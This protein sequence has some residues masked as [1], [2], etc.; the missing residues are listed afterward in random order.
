MFSIAFGILKTFI[1]PLLLTTTSPEFMEE[2]P[3]AY[4]VNS[5]IHGILLLGW[6]VT[7]GRGKWPER[8]TMSKNWLLFGTIF[9][10]VGVVIPVIWTIMIKNL[11]GLL[12]V[13]AI[14]ETVYELSETPFY[15]IGY[16][17]GFTL[18]KLE[19]NKLLMRFHLPLA[20]L[21]IIGPLPSSLLFHLGIPFSG[22]YAGPHLFYPDVGP[23]IWIFPYCL[24]D[25]WFWADQV[26]DYSLAMILLIANWR[27]MWIKT[28][29]SV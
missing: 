14:I 19:K 8:R 26:I 18:F 3:M 7:L 2:S 17:L 9:I 23:P 15:A 24:I 10:L 16:G 21:W 13:E 6:L 12:L 27:L 11:D 5:I 1:I 20:V 22:E 25:A 28:V 4:L 29:S